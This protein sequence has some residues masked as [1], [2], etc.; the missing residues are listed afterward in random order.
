MKRQGS[1]DPLELKRNVS[2][3]LRRYA[4]FG[5]S[6]AE[7]ARLFI[8]PG[9]THVIRRIAVG[10]ARSPVVVWQRRKCF[11]PADPPAKGLVVAKWRVRRSARESSSA[12]RRCRCSAA[13]VCAVSMRRVGA[14]SAD[15]PCS[16]RAY[17][18]GVLT[19]ERFACDDGSFIAGQRAESDELECQYDCYAGAECGPSRSLSARKRGAAPPS[20]FAGT[21]AWFRRAREGG[22]AQRPGPVR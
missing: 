16:T 4:D 14:P 9:S 17:A 18:R 2:D 20:L 10:S 3:R 22:V 15:A 7:N 13:W 12:C 8:I 5:H 6:T 19:G 11:P 1:T 21:G